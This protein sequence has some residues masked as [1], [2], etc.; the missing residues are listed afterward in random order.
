M[1]SGGGGG[2]CGGSIF[3]LANYSVAYKETQPNRVSDFRDFVRCCQRLF[4]FYCMIVKRKKNI[5]K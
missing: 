3:S 5:R 4:D 1:G 2:G